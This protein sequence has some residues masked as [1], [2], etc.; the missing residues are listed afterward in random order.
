MVQK[1][2]GEEYNSAAVLRCVAA[3]PARSFIAVRSTCCGNRKRIQVRRHHVKDTPENARPL[4]QF[5]PSWPSSP[6]YDG[7]HQ[8]GR[9]YFSSSW[10]SGCFLSALMMAPHLSHLPVHMGV[11]WKAGSE[12]KHPDKFLK[13]SSG[14]VRRKW[15]RECCSKC[16]SRLA[17]TRDAKGEN[18]LRGFSRTLS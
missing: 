16:H 9:P 17:N 14:R 1:E 3:L 13:F 6:F 12:N 11:S 4:L 5:P 2:S 7:H 10:L 8:Q 18:H 15:S